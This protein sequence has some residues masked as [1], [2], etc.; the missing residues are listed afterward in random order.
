MAKYAIVDSTNAV[1][2][3][4][5]WDGLTVWAPPTFTIAVADNLSTLAK[6]GSLYDYQASDFIYV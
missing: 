3:I 1:V 2:N 5:E 6:V 4:V